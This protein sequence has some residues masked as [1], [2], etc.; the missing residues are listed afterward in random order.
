MEHLKRPFKLVHAGGEPTIELTVKQNSISFPMNCSCIY[1]QAGT[2]SE[3]YIEFVALRQSFM[4][5]SCCV[6]EEQIE[7]LPACRLFYTDTH[8]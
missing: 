4:L 6:S 1:T 2:S 3:D 7:S 5:R 8:R